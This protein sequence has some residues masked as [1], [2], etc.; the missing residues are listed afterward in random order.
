MASAQTTGECSGG[1]DSLGVSEMCVSVTLQV[2]GG[3]QHT[4]V[5][6]SCSAETDAALP[7]VCLCTVLGGQGLALPCSGLS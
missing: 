6:L 4:T 5:K 3:L 2:C 1:C 7:A